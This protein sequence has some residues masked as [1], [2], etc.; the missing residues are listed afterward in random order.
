MQSRRLSLYACDWAICV[1]IDLLLLWGLLEGHHSGWLEAQVHL[2]MRDISWAPPQPDWMC[3][4]RLTFKSC[5]ISWMRHWKGSL[6][7]R[8]SIDFWY[9]WMSW[10]ATILG[11]NRFFMG[12]VAWHVSCRTKGRAKTY[13]VNCLFGSSGFGGELFVGGPA[14]A[15]V[16]LS[17]DWAPGR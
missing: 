12:Y 11:W 6:W 14:C 4:K 2:C 1:R 5:V 10:R 8:S 17:V 16:R 15:C 3:K 13:G 7:M 9:R